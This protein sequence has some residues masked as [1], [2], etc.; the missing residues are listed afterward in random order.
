MESKARGKK[1]QMRVAKVEK[2]ELG[3]T[4]DGGVPRTAAPGSTTAS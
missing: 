1:V 2:V 3:G 4:G